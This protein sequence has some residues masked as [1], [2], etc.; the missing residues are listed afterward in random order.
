[1]TEDEDGNN[2]PERMPLP[3][4]FVPRSH[5]IQT[6]TQYGSITHATTEVLALLAKGG[7]MGLDHTLNSPSTDTLNTMMKIRSSFSL[8]QVPQVYS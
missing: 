7:C 8:R 6:Y 5:P 4:K 2:A 1:M 3:T